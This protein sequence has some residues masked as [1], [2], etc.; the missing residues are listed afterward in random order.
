MEAVFSFQLLVSSIFIYA[1]VEK[2]RDVIDVE[3]V[4][5]EVLSPSFGWAVMWVSVFMLSLFL[6]GYGVS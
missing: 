5:K 4:L 6:I 2:Q 1:A 3:K